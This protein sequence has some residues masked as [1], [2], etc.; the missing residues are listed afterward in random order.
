MTRGRRRATYDDMIAAPEHL[1]AEILDGE[2]FRSPRPASPHAYAAS[3][4]EPDIARW[5]LAS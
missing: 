5:W 1:V 4:I 2:L 3:Q